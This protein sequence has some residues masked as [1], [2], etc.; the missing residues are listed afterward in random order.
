MITMM[1]MEKKISSADFLPA[2]TGVMK[3][4]PG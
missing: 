2:V 1:K 3:G 4:T